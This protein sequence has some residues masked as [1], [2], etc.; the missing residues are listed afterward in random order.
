[1]NVT[2]SS[3]DTRRVNQRVKSLSDTSG[4]S[5]IIKP[6]IAVGIPAYNEE[7]FISEIIR[8]AKKYTDEVIVVDDG[9]T[10]NTARVAEATGGH[11]IKHNRRQGAGGAT[12]TCFEAVKARNVDI[13][14]TLD[15]DN[16]HNPD[17][18]S[19]FITSIVRDKADLVIG[20]RFI[21]GH[22]NVPR[23]RR[24]GIAVIT[25]LFNVGSEVKISDAQSCFRAYGRKAL[26]SLII[27]ESGFGF[28]VELLEEARRKGF[29][30]TEIPVSCI[31]HSASH[32][33]NPVVHG[34][35]VALTV[36]KIRTR[37]LLGRPIHFKEPFNKGQSA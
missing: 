37:H 11:V 31:Y 29:Y 20:S 26:D 3:I 17:E 7:P 33:A 23:F 14:I 1:M 22:D 30:I 19:D 2:G 10:D 21:N 4:T 28:S 35:G 12:K 18:I 9:S 8:K 27:T 34:L 5:Q 6:K 25:W 16:Q 36:I 32:N 15:G 13:L 24:F